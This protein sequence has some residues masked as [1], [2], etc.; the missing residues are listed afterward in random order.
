MLEELNKYQY[1]K[2]SNSDIESEK[3]VNNLCLKLWKNSGYAIANYLG[4]IN[5]LKCL[6]SAMNDSD[7]LTKYSILKLIDSY[8]E[9]KDIP[10]EIK[11]LADLILDEFDYKEN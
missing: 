2:K 3:I 5:Q 6:A 11:N 9:G 7:R 1:I 10:D 4:A 8:R